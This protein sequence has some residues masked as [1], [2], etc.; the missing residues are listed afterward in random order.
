MC[1]FS[2]ASNA[3]LAKTTTTT[4]TTRSARF[5]LPSDRRR[6]RPGQIL[7]KASSRFVFPPTLP[8]GVVFVSPP[9][10]YTIE[11]PV[12]RIRYYNIILYRTQWP[13]VFEKSAD[14][15]TSPTPRPVEAVESRLIL[16][17]REL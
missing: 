11:K 14:I 1:R 8:A 12:T 16:L 10:N 2:P 13:A 5:M 6:R 17:Q 15:Y 9:P 3:L 4:T 7:F